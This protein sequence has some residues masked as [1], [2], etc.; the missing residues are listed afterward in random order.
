MPGKWRNFARG[1]T[2]LPLSRSFDENVY[3]LNA[4]L[5]PTSVFNHPRDVLADATVSRAEKRAICNTGGEERRADRRHSGSAFQSGSL[6]ANTTCRTKPKRWAR[7]DRNPSTLLGVPLL[8]APNRAL[9]KIDCHS[10]G[11]HRRREHGQK[12]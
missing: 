8:P 11:R 7:L 6:T 3:D 1:T 12:R 2:K 10:G 9:A 4:I 5:H